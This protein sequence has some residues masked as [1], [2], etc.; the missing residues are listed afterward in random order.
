MTML[1]LVKVRLILQIPDDVEE[2]IEHEEKL[3][4]AKSLTQSVI[5]TLTVCQQTIQD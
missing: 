5:A 1:L 4:T 3:Y 2:G